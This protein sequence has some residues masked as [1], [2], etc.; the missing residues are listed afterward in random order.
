MAVQAISD[1]SIFERMRHRN[2]MKL[3]IRQKI[4]SKRFTK[5]RNLL[6]QYHVELRDKECIHAY[7][8]R[9]RK[10]CKQRKMNSVLLSVCVILFVAFAVYFLFLK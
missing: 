10:E 1:N 9:I 4:K 2:L 7:K 8:N 3:S 6:D 5:Y